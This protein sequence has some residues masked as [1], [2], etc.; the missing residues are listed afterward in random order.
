MNEAPLSV[1]LVVC[2]ACGGP[3]VYASS[4]LFRPFCSER[5]KSID[6]GAWAN[7]DFR[8]SAETPLDD[9]V[10]GDPKSS[11]PKLQQGFSSR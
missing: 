1:K 8:L 2:P 11:D 7:E 5:C 10:Y 4:N 9:E 3:S 6:L